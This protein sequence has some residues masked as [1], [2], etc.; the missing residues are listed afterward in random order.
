MNSYDDYLEEARKQELIRFLCQKCDEEWEDES[1]VTTHPQCPTC[2]S[3]KIRSWT[4]EEI[5][6]GRC[7]AN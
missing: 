1:G 3:F 2:G 7:V 5:Y 4:R 6:G